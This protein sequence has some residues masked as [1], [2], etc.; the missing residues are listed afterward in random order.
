MQTICLRGYLNDQRATKIRCGSLM[1]AN[2]RTA[3]MP[4]RTGNFRKG[5]NLALA[6][7][8]K[9]PFHSE[10]CRSTTETMDDSYGSGGDFGCVLAMQD[11]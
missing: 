8:P 4:G 3:D 10:T 1:A 2:V 6:V 11:N 5:R 9:R 7:Y